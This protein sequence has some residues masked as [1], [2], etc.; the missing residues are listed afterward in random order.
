MLNT[1]QVS[2]IDNNKKNCFLSSKSSY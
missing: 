2:N 1:Y